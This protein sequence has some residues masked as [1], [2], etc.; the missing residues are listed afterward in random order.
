MPASI[1]IPIK[2]VVCLNVNT[3]STATPG[4]SIDNVSLELLL[5]AGSPRFRY[6]GACS[7]AWTSVHYPATHGTSEPHIPDHR[8]GWTKNPSQP[9]TLAQ[10][11]PHAPRFFNYPCNLKSSL[12]A[13]D[14]V[15]RQNH[16]YRVKLNRPLPPPEE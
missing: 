15:P 4:T 6:A 1:E 5:Y 3:T 10:P 11:A 12:P 14:R 16:C 13:W 9:R 2:L 7:C 8:L